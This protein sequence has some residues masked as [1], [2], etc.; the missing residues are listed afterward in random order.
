MGHQVLLLRLR[1]L[2]LLEHHF[3]GC[4]RRFQFMNDILCM[5][6]A[7]STLGPSPAKEQK[8]IHIVDFYHPASLLS[9]RILCALAKA[10]INWSPS[11]GLIDISS[12]D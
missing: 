1:K 9:R 4:S 6:E 11:S 7:Y 2:I 12:I 3:R 5:I 8:V 10:S